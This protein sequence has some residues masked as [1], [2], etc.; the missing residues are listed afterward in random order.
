MRKEPPCFGWLCVVLLYASYDTAVSRPDYFTA[1]SFPRSCV[2]LSVGGE[3][4]TCT[5][6]PI[7]AAAMLSPYIHNQNCT[8]AGT[9]SQAFTWRPIYTQKEM[10]GMD[11]TWWNIAVPPCFHGSRN[12]PAVSCDLPDA[13]CLYSILIGIL[14]QAPEVPL[15]YASAPRS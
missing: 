14:C 1:V 5:T 2:E 12:V 13:G 15:R 9:S 7:L 6:L 10:V 8:G 11:A 4:W 3:L